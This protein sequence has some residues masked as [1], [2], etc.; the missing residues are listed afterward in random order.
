MLAP[1]RSVMA[2]SSSHCDMDDMPATHDMSTMVSGKTMVHHNS[3]TTDTAEINHQCC[4]C[5]DGNTNGSCAGN[6]DMGM[7]ISLLIQESSYTPVFLEVAESNKISPHILVRAL[8]PP[9][10]PPAKLS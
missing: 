8:T 3:M 7:S 9:S 6:C 10:R 2:M 1:L 5:D 4:C